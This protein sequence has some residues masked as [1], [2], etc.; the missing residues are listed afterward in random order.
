MRIIAS[1]D[2]LD[3]FSKIDG[4]GSELESIE[5]GHRSFVDLIGPFA[6][7]ECWLK[8]MKPHLHKV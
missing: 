2:E 4:G 6:S 3:R 5:L 1:L 8:F 7:S